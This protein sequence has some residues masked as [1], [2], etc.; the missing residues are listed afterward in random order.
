MLVTERK[1]KLLR[2]WQL[3]Q[4]VLRLCEQQAAWL[5]MQTEALDRIATQTDEAQ[6]QAIPGLITDVEVGTITWF[7]CV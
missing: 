2:T 5:R 3:L 1:A 6:I 7:C 4:E